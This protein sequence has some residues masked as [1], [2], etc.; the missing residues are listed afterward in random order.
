[1]SLR[2]LHVLA[3]VDPASGGPVE[4]VQ[5]LT[6][7]NVEMGHHVEIVTLDDSA[8]PFLDR[9]GVKV[10]A[11]GPR[12]GGVYRYTPLFVPWLKDHAGEFDCVVVN[13]I[14]QYNLYGAWRALRG[15]KVPFFVFTHGMLD[16]WFKRRYPLKHLKKWLYWPWGVYPALQQARAVFFTC[17]EERRVARESFWL[18]EC[19]EF[20]LRYGIGGVPDEKDYREAFLSAH[21]QLRGK[22]LLLFL[23]RVAPKKG[24]DLL[25]RALAKIVDEG[26]V[27]RT[28]LRLVMAGPV[29]GAYAVKLQELARRLRIDDLVYW[30]GLVLGDVKWGAFQA[31]EAFVLPSHQENFGIAAA[32]ALSA[33]TPVLLG[34]GVNTWPEIVADGAGFADEPSVAGCAAVLRRWFALSAAQRSAMGEAARSCFRARYTAIDAAH[35]FIAALYLLINA[36]G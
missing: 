23:G 15:M 32:E 10:T 7:V 35:T 20:V 14:W 28:D 2:I 29:G 21:P 16:P 24:P 4:G 12:V 36:A 1:V 9:L 8:S 25:I 27:E 33:G 17:E 5:Q 30:P 19:R 13:G 26:I 6:R 18:Y 34:T 22:R 3:T 11:L 31:S